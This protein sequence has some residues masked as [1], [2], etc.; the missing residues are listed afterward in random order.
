MPV[1]QSLTEYSIEHKSY[2]ALYI[3]FT[4]NIDDNA[5]NHSIWLYRVLHMASKS[6]Y[7]VLHMAI[8]IDIV[9]WG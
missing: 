9:I 5:M 1:I 8:Y 6:I 7:G 4:I 2:G 3:P